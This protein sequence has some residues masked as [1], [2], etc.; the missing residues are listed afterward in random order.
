MAQYS[1]DTPVLFVDAF[2]VLF[3]QPASVLLREFVAMKQGLVFSAEKGCWPYL[4]GNKQFCLLF[5][6]DLFPFPMPCPFCRATNSFALCC[7]VLCFAVLCCAVLCCALCCAVL[8]FA[9][10]CVGAVII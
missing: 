4:D 10:C 7:A 2:D 3:A 8:C 6:Y 5:C 9:V 1:D